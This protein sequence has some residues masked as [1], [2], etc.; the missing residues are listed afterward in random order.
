MSVYPETASQTPVVPVEATP[1]RPRPAVDAAATSRARGISWRECVCLSQSCRYP[2][3]AAP[4]SGDAPAFFLA[5]ATPN[6][7]CL[8]SV[9]G[10]VEAP[11]ADSAP[12]A[13]GLGSGDVSPSGSGATYRE[14]Q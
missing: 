9:D 1:L 13:H 8:M 4:T 11:L 3:E 10:I 5:G 2:F 12:R 14:E 6:A 7:V